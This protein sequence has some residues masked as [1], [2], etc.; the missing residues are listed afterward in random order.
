MNLR[1]VH[2]ISTA[3]S[4]STWVNLILGSHPDAFSVGELKMALRPGFGD[5]AVHGRECPVLSRFDPDNEENP[6]LQ[7][8][9]LTGKSIFVVNNSRKF[10]PA[11][12]HDGIQSRFIHLVRDGRA[13]TASYLRKRRQPDMWHAARRWVHEVRRDSRLM[14][15][16][17]RQPN[18]R[19]QYE[20]M[21]AQPLEQLEKL[22]SLIGID[23][24]QAMLRYWE[25]EHHFF[26]GN[27][28]TLF[29]MLKKHDPSAEAPPAPPTSATG[30]SEN[31]RYYAQTNPASF[32][33]QRWKQQLTPRQLWVFRLLAGRTN[34]AIGYPSSVD[35]Q[36]A[37]PAT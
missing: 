11:Q 15:R 20:A 36:T 25:Q 16:L 10:L 17:R 5:C 26:G 13:V 2:I 19:L 7:L 9:R 37:E 28:G 24:D 32:D 18:C 8:Q 1:V 14:R 30:G 27:R 29:A 3:N 35:P 23:C 4:G 34:R 22:C 6:F 33:D 12:M 31:L 21:V